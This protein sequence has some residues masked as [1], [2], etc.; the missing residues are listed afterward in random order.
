MGLVGSWFLGGIWQ[1]EVWICLKFSVLLGYSF[2]GLL[3]TES[4]FL[5]VFFCTCWIS[6][7]LTLVSSL[8]FPER[9]EN[10]ANSSLNCS[11]GP[12]F[13][14]Q[15]VLS[16]PSRLIVYLLPIQC[17]EFL[18]IFRER[19]R[20]NV[21]LLPQQKF[22]HHSFFSKIIFLNLGDINMLKHQFYTSYLKGYWLVIPLS[23][24]NI[25]V[26]CKKCPLFLIS[27]VA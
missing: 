16:P 1:G 2:A 5:E 17:P 4:A 9:K 19:N 12:R 21:L 14:S 6:E 13:S 7:L 10:P 26:R 15:S 25:S 18:V 20:K 11:L 23:W 27:K 24:H 22:P 3:Y 8:G